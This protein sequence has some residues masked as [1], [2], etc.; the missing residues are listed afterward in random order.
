M[1]WRKIGWLTRESGLSRSIAYWYCSSKIFFETLCLLFKSSVDAICREAKF[2]SEVLDEENEE[3]RSL[4]VAWLSLKSTSTL[5]RTFL[6][7]LKTVLRWKL[8]RTYASYVWAHQMQFDWIA[9]RNSL[10]LQNIWPFSN[11]LQG[12]RPLSS[13]DCWATSLRWIRTWKREQYDYHV[14]TIRL[15]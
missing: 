3:K 15:S 6:R 11:E 7:F 13:R 12:V 9:L 5:L 1:L 8:V 10:R 2:D 4:S 14:I